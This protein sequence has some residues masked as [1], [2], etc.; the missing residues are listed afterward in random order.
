MS[1]HKNEKIY[2]M[3]E[4]VEIKIKTYA[5]N[6]WTRKNK[7]GED[8]LHFVFPTPCVSVVHTQNNMCLYTKETLTFVIMYMYPLI[9]IYPMYVY[10][11]CVYGH[12]CIYTGV[13]Y[14]CM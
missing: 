5:M 10:F 4:N 3:K 8:N 14:T 7:S 6:C 2:A 1:C 13:L 11:S 9:C 12:I